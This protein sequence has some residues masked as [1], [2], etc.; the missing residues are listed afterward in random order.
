MI[1][2]TRNVLLR[3]CLVTIALSLSACISFPRQ[4]LDRKAAVDIKRIAVIEVEDPAEYQVVNLGG[5]SM[6]F[7]LIGGL[8][9]A[10]DIKAKTN[11]FTV[12]AKDT[13]LH[14]G[15]ELGMQL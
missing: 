14:I 2:A 3:L 12:A 15:A 6:A 8:I 7:G 11:V 4:T 10:A 1:A 5:A 13:K 9:Q